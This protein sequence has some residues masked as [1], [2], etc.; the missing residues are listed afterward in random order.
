MLGDLHLLPLVSA[1]L[2]VAIFVLCI[3]GYRRIYCHPLSAFPGP[4]LAALTRWYG[5]Y[6]DVIQQGAFLRHKTALHDI[7]GK[8]LSTT[9][10]LTCDRS[11][12]HVIYVRRDHPDRPKRSQ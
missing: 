11:T 1:S 3:L 10:D 5:F 8:S 9:M 7:Y 2:S 12:Y 6:Y 4:R